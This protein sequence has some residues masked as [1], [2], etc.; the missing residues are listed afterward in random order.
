MKTASTFRFGLIALAATAALACGTAMAQSTSAAK[1]P[2]HGRVN[3][4]NQRI[5]NQQARTQ[6]GL[7]NGTITGKQ[8]AH[9]ESRDANIA[10]RESADEAKHNGHLTKRETHR[11]NKAENRNSRAIHRQRH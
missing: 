5:D 8:A 11:L 10:Q 2:G 3:E 6:A 9:D 4:V 7:A 1:V